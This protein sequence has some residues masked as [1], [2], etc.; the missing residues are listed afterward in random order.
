MSQ[1]AAML[2][3]T[4]PTSAAS[5]GTRWQLHRGL[6]RLR[7]GLY[8]LRGRLPQRGMV[9]ELSQV[10]PHRSRLRR[11]LRHH[12]TRCCPGTP[13]TTPTSPR[14]S[15]RHAHTACASCAA[16]VRGPCRHARALPRLRRCLPPLRAGMQR[17]ARQPRLTS[18]GGVQACRTRDI[19][20]IHELQNP[21]G[22]Y[23]SGVVAPM[24]SAR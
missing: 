16:R 24:V 19:P 4:R 18:V 11:H 8:R 13:A 2:D 10:H 1:T 20:D 22:V 14:A 23:R 12:R 5:T 15:C 9:A 7:P 6:L 17:A 3:T 21:Q